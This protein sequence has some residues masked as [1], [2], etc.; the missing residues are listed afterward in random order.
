VL[1]RFSRPSPAFVL[2]L[3]ALFV[4]LGGTAV[5][6]GVV[7]LARRA[8]QADNAAKLGGQTAAAISAAAAQQPGPASSAAGLVSQKTVPD[9]VPPSNTKTISVS[10]DGGKKVVGAGWSSDGNVLDLGNRP[11]G[12]TT[13]T[14]DLVNFGTAQANVSLYLTCIG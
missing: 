8:L 14:F 5:A 10:C 3:I 1:P 12:D 13:W 4:S 11:T 6:A 2:A 9:A 7:P